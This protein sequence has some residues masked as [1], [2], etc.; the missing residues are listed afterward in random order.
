MSE[1]GL[2]LSDDELHELTGIKTGHYQARWLDKQ[3]PP[4]PFS[5][6]CRGKPRVL[7]AYVEKRLGLGSDE[8]TKR[9]EPDFSHWK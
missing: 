7:R 4:Y 9:T 3:N 5:L 8:I 1:Q 6:N 2:F